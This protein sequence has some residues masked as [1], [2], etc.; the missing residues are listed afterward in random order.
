MLIDDKNCPTENAIET[1]RRRF[2]VEKEIDRILTR[3]MR[4]RSSGPYSPVNLDTLRKGTESLI[5]SNYDGAFEISD[6]RW[7]AGG[8]SKLQMAF[9]LSWH[10]PD[11][12]KKTKTPM[13]LRME[14]KESVVE[15]SR[16]REYQVIQAFEGIVPVPPV[17]WVDVDA[18]HLPYPGLIYGFVE[19]VAKPTA[20]S[21]N[22]TGIRATLGPHYRKILAPQYIEHLA[23]IHTHDFTKSDLSS[24]DIPK[25]GTEAVELHLNWWERVWEEDVDE[26]VPL[27][28]YAAGWLRDNMPPVDRLSILHGDYRIG[29]CLFTEPTGR[30][31]AWLDWELS[32]IGDRHA[33]WGYSTSHLYDE[34]AEDGKTVFAQGLM[35]HEEMFEKYEKA[36]GLSLNPKALYYYKVFAAYKQVSICLSSG[37]RVPRG[38]KSH[39]DVV[40]LWLMSVSYPIL[41]ELRRLLEKGRI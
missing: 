39:Q 12:G 13:V 25:L 11:K 7:L 32:S 22:V 5:R 37:Y 10:D 9:S 18:N 40:V 23:A 24:F 27:M 6:V 29:N 31:T 26:D 14:P 16:L 30:I 38:S 3:K 21:S 19:G 35:P 20:S 41:E 36:S 34:L 8:A 4:Q 17:Y 28:R 2:R 1:V 15:T 33:D